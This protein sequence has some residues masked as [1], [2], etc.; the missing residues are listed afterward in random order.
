MREITVCAKCGSR[1]IEY[2]GGGKCYCNNCQ[3]EQDSEDKYIASPQERTRVA[4]YATGNRWAIEN[5][6]ATH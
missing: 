1:D 5:F 3:K 6:N 4:V 2:L